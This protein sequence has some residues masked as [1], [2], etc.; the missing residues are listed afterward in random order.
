MNPRPRPRFVFIHPFFPW[1]CTIKNRT[2]KTKTRLFLSNLSALTL[3][4]PP[5]PHPTPTSSPRTSPDK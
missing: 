5:P 2:I 3:P 4:P 1:R